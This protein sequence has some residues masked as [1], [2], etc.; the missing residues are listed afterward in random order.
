M[1]CKELD[2]KLLPSYS[3]LLS[4]LIF[5]KIFLETE[6]YFYSEKII[7]KDKTNKFI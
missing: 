5:K 1:F 2:S 7:V 6:F 3:F 4:S